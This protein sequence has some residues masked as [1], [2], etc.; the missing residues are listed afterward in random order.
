M[1]A[2]FQINSY[3]GDGSALQTKY[4]FGY[5]ETKE[6]KVNGNM[7]AV[8]KFD[9]KPKETITCVVKYFR[10]HDLD[11]SLRGTNED[12][13]GEVNICFSS[14]SHSV[15]WILAEERLEESRLQRIYDETPH[16]FQKEYGDIKN[17]REIARKICQERRKWVKKIYII[18]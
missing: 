17:I 2:A 16:Y 14:S 7:I 4:V 9:D 18:Y 10:I 13:Y 3:A 8:I 15:I 5:I 1:R 11:M 6:E 12:G